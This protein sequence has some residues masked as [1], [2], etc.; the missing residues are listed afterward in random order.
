MA[1][2]EQR[3]AARPEQGRRPREGLSRVWSGG[4]DGNERLTSITGTVLLALL[5][6]IGVTIL[7]IGQLLWVH[8]FVGLVLI[9][10]LVLKLAST[11][12]RFARYYSGSS[13]YRRKGPPALALRALAPALVT[14]T[15]LVF[16]TGILLL[17]A[18]PRGRGQLL[19]LHKVGFIVWIAFFALHVLGHLPELGRLVRSVGAGHEM[20]GSIA[21]SAGRWIS[22]AGALV[23]G[24]ILAIVLI[25]DFAA[26]T[27][28]AAALHHH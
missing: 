24:V 19:M 28:H 25:P 21:G 5:A 16:V 22:L 26:W 23:A 11:G 7:R 15:I 18:G 20:P 13:A 4:T 8:L 1:V 12:Y 9:G 2:A 6:V 3:S 14:L 17:I 27:T 10:P